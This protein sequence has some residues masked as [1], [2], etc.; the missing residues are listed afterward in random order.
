MTDQIPSFQQLTRSFQDLPLSAKSAA[1]A[2]V[3]A[4]D[5]AVDHA[6]QNAAQAGPEA[7]DWIDQFSLQFG[8]L[9]NEQ[10]KENAIPNQLETPLPTQDKETSC[11]FAS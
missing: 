2:T 9:L 6:Y 5:D 4:A 8:W 11:Q 1:R 7:Q 3:L 10:T